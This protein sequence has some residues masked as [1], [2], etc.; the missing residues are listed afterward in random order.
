M[1]STGE[2]LGIGKTMAE[3]L[4]KGLTAANLA[5]PFNRAKRCGVLLSVE[6]NDYLDSISLAKRFYDLGITVYATSGTALLYSDLFKHCTDQTRPT[7]RPAVKQ[8]CLSTGQERREKF[9]VPSDQGRGQGQGEWHFQE[10][11]EVLMLC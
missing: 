7:C 11:P 1:K 4:F 5:V 8:A 9:H 2:V 10:K 3:A 6:E